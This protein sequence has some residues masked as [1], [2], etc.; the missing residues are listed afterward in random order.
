MDTTPHPKFQALQ[1]MLDFNPLQRLRTNDHTNL[2]ETELKSLVSHAHRDLR[3]YDSEVARLQNTI[4]FLKYE[5]RELGEHVR[6]CESFRAPVRR[7]PQELFLEI[8]RAAEPRLELHVGGR[9]GNRLQV[10]MAA[11]TAISNVCRHW[12]VMYMKSPQL[13]TDIL[14]HF[15]PCHYTDSILQDI[16]YWFMYNME[17]AGRVPLQLELDVD[18]SFD[19]LGEQFDAWRPPMCRLLQRHMHRLGKFTCGIYSEDLIRDLKPLDASSLNCLVLRDKWDIDLSQIAPNI[20]SLVFHWH[21]PDNVF[22]RQ[23]VTTL[24]LG[25]CPLSAALACVRGCEG[26]QTLILENIMGGGGGLEPVATIRLLT[27][28]HL[29]V[30]HNAPTPDVVL[31]PTVEV[32]KVFNLPALFSL[33]II[34]RI[35]SPS[36]PETE[37]Q[38]HLLV[39]LSQLI[40]RSSCQ[41]RYLDVT[42]NHSLH[43]PSLPSFL[44]G[45]SS[46]ETLSIGHAH[47]EGAAG[48]FNS[49]F[50]YLQ[51]R[52]TNGETSVSPLPQLKQVELKVMRPSFDDHQ[53]LDFVGSRWK[54]PTMAMY[55]GPEDRNNAI[56]SIESVL[57]TIINGQFDEGLW[58]PL[59]RR[60][61][62]GLRI[63]VHDKKG[64]V[65]TRW[66]THH[67]E[68]PNNTHN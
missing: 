45:I 52:Q 24:N 15:L 50:K 57:L 47:P 28:T 3:A 35:D 49:V 30:V 7:L 8:C 38:S 31:M 36:I 19:D 68:N 55:N 12:Q 51:S 53:F 56:A 34:S 10:V 5:K 58:E 64:C 54:H 22:S 62:H 63:A 40:T 11:K 29:S 23:R 61:L 37:M 1:R 14:L 66:E 16:N 59:R 2:S 43:I 6:V 27:L 67:L 26:L 41:L 44:T 32:F 60:Q 17:Y 25:F 48:E 21:S 9:A 46:L 65:R 18:I 42:G 39:E 20:T 13:F 33:K 4:E